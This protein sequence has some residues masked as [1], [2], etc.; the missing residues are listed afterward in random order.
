MS[1]SGNS[2][3]PPVYGGRR[4]T[5][6]VL[7]RTT[8]RTTVDEAHP[9]V[10]DAVRYFP[11]TGQIPIVGGTGAGDEFD[12]TSPKLGAG[13][14]AG[15]RVADTPA[16]PAASPSDAYLSEETTPRMASSRAHSLRR[17]GRTA[18][19]GQVQITPPAQQAPSPPPPR[20][21]RGAD[22]ESVHG[23]PAP[24]TG[25]RITIDGV[26]LRTA[27]TAS[28]RRESESAAAPIGPDTWRVPADEPPPGGLARRAMI[29][30]LRPWS[31]E[32]TG[33][34]GDAGP[35]PTG[36][37]ATLP[38]SGRTA[39]HHAGA[40]SPSAPSRSPSPSPSP[41]LGTV[42]R[43]RERTGA[44]ELPA[45]P[46]G[47][48]RT[49]AGAGEAPAFTPAGDRATG[50]GRA[51]AA[52]P[53]RA[54]SRGRDGNAPRTTAGSR[55]RAA[56]TA[57]ALW[58]G[59]AATIVCF[60]A[61]WS[62]AFSADEA[63]TIEAATR[64]WA[65]MWALITEA[66]AANGVWMAITHLWIGA[67]GASELALRLLPAVAAGA[68]VAGTT[69]IG[70]RL[71]GARTGV[72]AG[73]IAVLLPRLTLQGTEASSLA[74]AIALATWSTVA[75]TWA[76]GVD[77]PI[78]RFDVPSRLV[79]RRDRARRAA[80]RWRHIGRWTV[81]ALL[82]A[83]GAWVFA[84]VVLMALVHP[85]FVMISTPRRGVLR[86]SSLAS[87][88][89][90]VLASPL[91]VVVAQQQFVLLG[92][93]DGLPAT[94]WDWIG[95]PTMTDAVWAV[96]VFVM[97]VVTLG[98]AAFRIR[99]VVDAA[100]TAAAL[101]GILWLVVPAAGL[102]LLQL[103]A[104]GAFAPDYLAFTAPG[105]ALL[106][107][108]AMSARPIWLALVLLL[109]TL[110]SCL[111]PLVMQKLPTAK[112]GSD[113]RATA[114]YIATNAAD[115]DGIVFSDAETDPKSSRVML[116]T[117]P[118]AFEGL[119]DLT[120]SQSGEASGTLW[121]TSVDI[122]TVPS[123]LDEVDR[124]WVLRPDSDPM[125]S[126]TPEYGV[127]TGEGF[128]VMSSAVFNEFIVYELVRT[129]AF[130]LDEDGQPPAP[131]PLPELPQPIP[132]NYDGSDT[133]TG[134]PE[135]TTDGT[136]TGAESGTE[137]DAGVGPSGNATTTAGDASEGGDG[138]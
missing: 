126:T 116:S 121:D 129:D 107:G 118:R 45:F 23:S 43:E 72:I 35:A 18:A 55:I 98:I 76:V 12:Q 6:G 124:V 101:L 8:E 2:G 20:P 79:S 125:T 13:P 25:P 132:T 22:T 106:L 130:G 133:G 131:D 62:P 42:T 69:L 112:G 29:E 19:D 123:R 10:P 71:A 78:P 31:D 58:L 44:I 4:R 136:G 61:S 1:E 65:G 137:T 102:G 84:P 81:V 67:F 36:P 73:S 95:V 41:S 128:A 47:E 96:P 108:A 28:P 97:T 40:S 109:L 90:I 17:T 135:D 57:P 27:P 75:V 88:G 11:A 50:A 48:P 64:D 138:A 86:G 46:E 77:D 52:A 114:E 111:P 38:P 3:T 120:L 63:F 49:A 56:V 26:A 70:T 89:A 91:L 115:G 119:L 7:A 9:T 104:P 122:A 5:R 117:Y 53:A 37:I 110:H 92:R 60:I 94:A 103:F 39:P 100:G 87:L 134:N 30:P 113:D 74:A 16:P 33:T 85:L 66:H 82:V 105:L 127:Y 32:A 93:A 51:V 24:V 21:A 59:V 15:P 34:R 54:G 68:T 14:S 83:A 99:K 80:A